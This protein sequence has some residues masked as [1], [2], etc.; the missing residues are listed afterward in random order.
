MPETEYAGSE[1]YKPASAQFFSVRCC[2]RGRGFLRAFLAEEG[3]EE[4]GALLLEDAARDLDVVVEKPLSEEVHPAARG[5]GFRVV[6]AED[7]S[8]DARVYHR[9]RAHGTGLQ[10]DIDVAVFQPPVAEGFCRALQRHDLGMADGG[11]FPLLEVA[12]LGDDAAVLYDDGAHGHLV[13]LGALG[14]ELQRPPHKLFIRCGVVHDRPPSAARSRPV[15]PRALPP[16]SALS[17]VIRRAADD[18][19]CTVEL[20]GEHHPEKLVREGHGA[21]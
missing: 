12:P 10:G 2:C 4:G 18:G 9:T 19:E 17:F 14:G 15:D 5:A 3:G 6:R 8:A 11:I 20:L 7:D 1:R 13:R 21:E 16:A